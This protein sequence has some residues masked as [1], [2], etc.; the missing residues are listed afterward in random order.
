MPFP[1]LY[2]AGAAVPA[3]LLIAAAFLVL[4][5]VPAAEFSAPGVPEYDPG[6][7]DRAA[8]AL[9]EAIRCRTVSY[10]DVTRRDF[11]QWVAL[12]RVLRERYPLSHERMIPEHTAGLSTLYKWESP[13]P[14]G[15]PILLCAHLDVVPAGGVW[16]VPPFDGHIG[17]GFVW[18]RGALDCKNVVVCLFS[19]LESL[20][21]GG[22]VPGRDIYLALGHD[23]ELGGPEGAKQF[24]RYF[25]QHGIHFSLV[26]DEGGFITD[27]AFPAGK[28]VADICAA[29]KGVMD[30]RLT[31]T[32]PGGHS[33]HPPERTAA[34]LLCEAVCRV[35]FKLRPARILPLVYDHFNTIAPLLDGTLRRYAATPRFYRKKLLARLCADERTAALVRTTVAPTL[36]TG[37]VAPNVLPPSAEAN[38]NI[39]LLPGDDA[40]GLVSWI[41][42]L[43]RDLGVKAEIVL[44]EEPS[45]VSD[46]KG[47]A[48]SALAGAVSDVFPGIPAVPGL[49]CGASDARHYEPFSSAVLRFSPF[50]VTLNE[51]AAV[52][53]ENERVAV[54]SLGAAVRFYRR[55]I[56]RFCS[57]GGE[58][59]NPGVKETGGN[60][61]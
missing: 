28:P 50:I 26:L 18:G 44:N 13:E 10:P 61:I 38:L 52:H 53:A 37:G 41:N 5:K 45:G 48:F 23:E 59:G 43:T 40:E 29:E 4:R 47:A 22:F 34:G 17:D 31:V 7:A 39:R 8:E 1:A 21:E 60:G 56:E 49:C 55:V 6:E 24:A 20:F 36:L 3:L 42:A 54:A 46:Y 27:G 15:E 2:Y 9:A 14:A 58:Q 12:R 25:A 19:A 33:S 35:G 11:S 30:V 16:N 32:A 57:P 51:L